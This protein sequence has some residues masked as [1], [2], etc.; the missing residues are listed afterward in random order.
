MTS[1]FA[2]EKFRPPAALLIS[3]N[4]CFNFWSAASKLTDVPTTH[5]LP[6]DSLDSSKAHEGRNR[7]A[8]HCRPTTGGQKVDTGIAVTAKGGK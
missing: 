7:S 3:S 4:P 1:A 5:Y 8:T 6:A 2:Q